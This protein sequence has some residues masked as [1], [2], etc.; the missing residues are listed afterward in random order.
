VSYLD[1]LDGPAVVVYPVDDVIV[2][3]SNPVPIL[4]GE[5]LTTWRSRAGGQPLD[6]RHE[7]PELGLGDGAEFVF[8]RLLDEVTI[9]GR[10]A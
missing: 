4:S 8:S 5:F 6:P 7:T 2:T 9:G 3:L 10:H 1:D